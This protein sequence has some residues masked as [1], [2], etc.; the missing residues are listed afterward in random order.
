MLLLWRGIGQSIWLGE[1]AEITV[2]LMNVQGNH[3][4][5]GF[6]APKDLKI[7]RQEI[8]LGKNQSKDNQPIIKFKKKLYVPE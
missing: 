4:C 8:A 2:T 6:M 7:M 5:L 3:A 1:Q